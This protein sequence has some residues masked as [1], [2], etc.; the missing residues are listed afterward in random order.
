MGNQVLGVLLP[1]LNEDL[2]VVILN[3]SR[4]CDCEQTHL[5]DPVA[6]SLGGRRD[7]DLLPPVLTKKELQVFLDGRQ[8]GQFSWEVNRSNARMVTVSVHLFLQRQVDLIQR[9]QEQLK[10]RGGE[11]NELRYDEVVNVTSV[12]LDSG[13]LYCCRVTCP[14]WKLSMSPVFSART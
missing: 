14:L 11:Y 10:T 13:T 3:Q 6:V 7:D 2:T 1:D 5:S 4:S 9:A 12:S 8:P